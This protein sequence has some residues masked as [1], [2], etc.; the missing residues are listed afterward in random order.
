M[1]AEQERVRYHTMIRDLPT[2]ERPRERLK[3]YGPSY[4]S[5]VELI[6]VLLRTGLEGES[7]LSMATRLLS[8]FQGLG[9]LARATYGEMCAQKGISE[10]KACQIM[11]ALELGRRMVSLQPESLPVIS[12]P[13]DVANLLMGEMSLLE[14]EHF[15][16]MLLNT[17]NQGMGVSEIYIG[18]VN[19]ALI[20]TAEVYRPAI[21]E[22]CP[23]IM[24]IATQ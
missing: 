6:A 11:A 8:R 5:N 3:S 20:R 15:R 14:Q 16:V 22:N 17:R 23:A 12:S 1:T 10:A 18:N 19:T 7:V 24:F 4:L 21:R 9:G 13:Q 2:G